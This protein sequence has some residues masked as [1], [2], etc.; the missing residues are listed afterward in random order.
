LEQLKSLLFTLQHHK[1]R[2][3]IFFSRLTSLSI[4]IYT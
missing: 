4:Y 1:E 2:R 3:L